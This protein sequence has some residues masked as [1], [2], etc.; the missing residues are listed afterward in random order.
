MV[1]RLSAL[2]A[3]RPLTSPSPEDPWHSFLLEAESPTRALARLEGLGQL[4][5]HGKIRNR[6][7]GL[8]ACTVVVLRADSPG[9]AAQW[10]AESIPES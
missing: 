3:G 9:K 5:Q 8:T 7:R 2:H 4:G 6:I 1:V 10:F